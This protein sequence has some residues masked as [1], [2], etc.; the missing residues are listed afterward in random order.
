MKILIAAAGSYG[1]VAPYTGLGVRLREA[2]HTVALAADASYAQLVRAAGLEFRSLPADPRREGSG[3]PG[4]KR[5]LMRRAAAFVRELG[6]GIAGAATT[7][8]DLLLLSATTAPL[9]RHVAEALGIPSLDL[10]LQPNAPTG[11]FPPVVTGTRSLG[12]WGNRAA[13]RLSLRIVDRLYADGVRDLRA[14]LGLPPA[15]ARA[16]RRRRNTDSRPVLHGVSPALVPRPADWRPGLELVG[17]WWP[18]TAPD[19]ALPP[20]LESF[21][22]AGPPPVFVGFGSMAAGARDNGG[23]ERLAATVV[24]ALRRAGVRGVIQSGWAGLSGPA[25]GADILTVGEVPHALLFPRTAAVVHHAGAG[26]TAAA[27]RAGV[28]AV[29]VPVT[30]DQPFWAA[31]L[32]AVGAG[33]DAVPFRSLA[34]EGAVE[35]LAEAIGRAVREPSYRDAATAVAR[36]MEAED[37]AGEVI[38]AVESAA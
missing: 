13:G 24:G 17:N 21:L 30:A 3:A 23:S 20:E 32:A 29:P 14:Q 15:S 34:A 35:R 16:V 25:G 5:E 10:P 1:D 18:Y 2:G 11:A 28:P 6:P 27:L 9:G 38:K 7:D 26:T 36:R 4:G 8:T 19:A 31:R 22:A 37:G 12:R 33:T